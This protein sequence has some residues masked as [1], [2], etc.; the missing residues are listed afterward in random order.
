MS[1]RRAVTGLLVVG[2]LTRCLGLAREIII[3]RTFGTSAGLDAVYL[4]IAVP[5]A[6][7]VGLG[8]G[9]GRAVV[10]TA[11]ALA[12]EQLGGLFRMAVRRIMM[13]AVPLALL[14]AA[15]APLWAPLLM[16]ADSPVSPRGVVIAAAASSLAIMGG[17]FA[18]LCSGLANARGEHLSA[19]MA[20]FFHNS[21]VIGS[22]VL[23]SPKLGPYSLLVGIVA[24]EWLQALSVV[25]FVRR[26]LQRF[27]TPDPA[28]LAGIQ[29]MFLPAIL[30]ATVQGLLAATDRYFAAGISEGAVS[31]LAYAE[32]LL[33]FPVLLIGL[34]IQGPLFTR[35]AVHAA[36]ERPEQFRDTVLFGIRTLLLVSAPIVAI[37][38]VLPNVV[39]AILLQRGAFTGADSLVAAGVLRGYALG[40]PFMCMVPLLTSAG[41]AR[42]RQWRV[43][44]A[45]FIILA[46]NVALDAGLS[47]LFGLPGISL[48]SAVN[49]FLLAAL[50]LRESAEG[51]LLCASLWKSL[52]Y[53]MVSASAGGAALLALGRVWP[54]PTVDAGFTTLVCYLV[55]GCTAAGAASGLVSLPA[56]RQW[57]PQ[58]SG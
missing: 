54:I 24:A 46:I 56:L 36:E 34:A 27:D 48:A 57:K 15:T 13:F 33:N 10:P 23:L 50:L 4:G 16:P 29:A 49:G 31:A 42:R 43:V 22:V 21:T 6:L 32:R 1:L 30:L 52:G 44:R 19:S 7:T 47:R 20:A 5:V 41:L 2:V 58:K 26:I 37:V 38:A 8:G 51:G 35:L 9:I 25:P 28:A 40:I 39:V 14:L 17:A 18:G 12:G 53:A 11:A 55:A 45:Y 3:A